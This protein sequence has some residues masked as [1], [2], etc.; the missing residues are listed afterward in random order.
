M[1]RL[2]TFLTP[3][4]QTF[5]LST[6]LSSSVLAD[7]FS[8]VFVS[9]K[10]LN[11]NLEKVTLIDM[12]ERG[13]Y[14]K[15]HLPGAIWVNYDWLIK[16][17]DGLS[18]SGG[19]KY[20][21]R[22]LSQLGISNDTHVVIYDDVGGME[23]SRLYW[24]LKKLNHSKVQILDGG[25]INWVLHGHKVT[26]ALP[27]KPQMAQ[28]QL[29]KKDYTNQLTADKDETL[30]AI[31]DDTIT[32]IDTRT[33]QEYQ[34]H[35]KQ[36]QSGHIPGAV[37]FEWSDAIDVHSGFKQLDDSKILKQL[38]QVGIKEKSQPIILYCNTAHRAARTFTMLKSLGFSDIKLYDGSTQEYSLDKSL[39]F[40]LGIQP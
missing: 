27:Q 16:S 18:L 9:T 37:W 34:G 32:L 4:F 8:E 12:S 23:A 31:K 39:P 17:Q 15:F 28:Y 14:Q 29:P 25:S 7:T 10:W 30:A 22:V 3:L 40:K 38:S 5:I 2:S 35:P 20:M 19:P 33:K 26:Q 11:N 36:K 24:E 21:A 13:A 6:L 1:T